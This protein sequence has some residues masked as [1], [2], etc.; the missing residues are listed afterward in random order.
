MGFKAIVLKAHHGD[1]VGRARAVSEAMQE[2]I[3]VFGGI[4]LNHF[5]GGFNPFAVEAALRTGARMV[6]MPTIHALNHLQTYGSAGYT[7][8][9]QEGERMRRVEGLT[10]LNSE[11]KLKKNV[12]EILSLVAEADACLA[13]GHLKRDEIFA[14]CHAAREQNVKRILVNH[15]D[16]EMQQLTSNE[17]HELARAGVFLEKTFLPLTPAWGGEDIKE[18][19]RT[20][21]EAGP[22]QCVIA[23]D[24]GQFGNPMPADGFVT[25]YSALAKEGFSE[26]ELSLM[27]EDNP[28]FLLGL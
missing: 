16:M 14:L 1:T 2:R 18:H 26:E 13:T 11:Q 20:I 3:Q 23:S 24:L 5:V 22:A 28:S 12:L 6:W 25:F 7:Q 4:V 9:E 17:Q 27:A 15:P 19:V 10:V 21:R 8:M